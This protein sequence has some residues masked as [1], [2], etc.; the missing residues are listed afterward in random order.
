MSVTNETL[1]CEHE[2]RWNR[3]RRKRNLF[4]KKA[5]EKAK[6]LIFLNRSTS[7]T[8]KVLWPAFC[9]RL[10][11]YIHVGCNYCWNTGGVSDVNFIVMSRRLT[12]DPDPLRPSWFTL[13][14][15]K[16]FLGRSIVGWKRRPSVMELTWK[17]VLV[18]K[19]TLKIM[20]VS[21]SCKH[22]LCDPKNNN[23]LWFR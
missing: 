22:N 23:I 14:S 10:W 8:G 21:L 11:C 15:C 16:K 5:S 12:Y 1:S 4:R 18:A 6:H 19:F 13:S 9:E 7:D 17:C 2:W 20:C 3:A